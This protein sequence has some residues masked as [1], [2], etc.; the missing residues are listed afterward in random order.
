VWAREERP[1]PSLR[2][3]SPG[4]PGEARRHG[5]PKTVKPWHPQN[6]EGAASLAGCFG[7]ILGWREDLGLVGGVFR[8]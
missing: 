3:T 4:G 7:W 5:L 2:D 1:P 8:G 6:I